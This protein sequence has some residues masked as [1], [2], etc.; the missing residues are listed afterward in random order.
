MTVETA[1][2]IRAAND[3]EEAVASTRS[4]KDIWRQA[5]AT[6]SDLIGHRLFT[7]LLHDAEQGDV[8][9]VY[10]S[11]PEAYPVSGR[12]AM[13]STP[14]G[15]LVLQEGQVFL[16]RDVQHIRWA[17]PDH[18]VIEGLGLGSVINLPLR[19]LGRTYGTINLLH[20]AGFYRQEQI[21]VARC[22]AIPLVPLGLHLASAANANQ[23]SGKEHAD[24]DNYH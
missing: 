11:H 3:L 15:K 24:N 1:R 14:W 20:E 13:G 18:A 23:Q 17:F 4:L 16:G 22:L 12:K 19:C 9:R 2:L 8:E 10:T 21:G 5:D 6:F 7:V